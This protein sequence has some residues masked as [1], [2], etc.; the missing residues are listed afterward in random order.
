MDHSYFKKSF[1]HGLKMNFQFRTNDDRENL[2]SLTSSEFIP[3]NN[4]CTRLP[5]PLA[6]LF[7]ASIELFLTWIK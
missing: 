5:E 1:F 6:V 4:I 2:P 7:Y 3:Y